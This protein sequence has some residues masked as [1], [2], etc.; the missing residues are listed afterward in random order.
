MSSSKEQERRRA[1]RRPILDTF[2]LFVVVPK[3]GMH[4]LIAHDIS[5]LGIGFDIDVD[6]EDP[7]ASPLEKGEVLSIRF[8]V[9]QSLF[10]PLSV[11]VAR[12][13]TSRGIRRIGAEFT[14]QQS[15]TYL[16]FAHF[17]M[18][19]DRIADVVQIEQQG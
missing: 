19:L 8:Y 7:A 5:E 2:A 6:Q 14:D 12:V 13:D 11:T 4:R 3:K 18:T 16:A 17:L 15:P 10:I 9:N 1:R